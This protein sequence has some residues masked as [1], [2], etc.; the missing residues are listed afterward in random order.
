MKLQAIEDAGVGEL[1]DDLLSGM[2]DILGEN[3][4]GLYLYGSLVWGDFDR[5]LSD[6]DMLAAVAEDLSD[7]EAVALKRLHDDIAERYPD[8]SDRIE[9]QY[10]SLEGLRTFRTESTPMAV[11]SP[12]EP[13]HI[14]EGNR[15]WLIN[16]YFVREYGVALYGPPP[17]TIIGPITKEEFVGNVVEHARNWP[18]W[19]EQTRHS[20]PYQGYA[21]LTM[22][23][24]LYTYRT[25]EQVSKKQAAEWAEQEMPEWAPLIRSALRWREEKGRDQHIDHEA[26]FPE[27]ERFF[28]FVSET[29]AA[30]QAPASRHN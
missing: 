3:L 16:W 25:G 10:L 17:E 27:T 15:D 19:L 8:W 26:T 11:I 9:V 23:R 2:R 7:T 29:I 4:V 28:R 6:I 22:C 1:L 20:R 21:I 24:T 12:G 13:F 5:Y 30:E 14:V 18:R